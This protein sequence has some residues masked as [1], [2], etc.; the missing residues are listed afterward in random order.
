MTLTPER[1]DLDPSAFEQ[2]ENA[3]DALIGIVEKNGIVTGPVG[4]DEIEGYRYYIDPA[5]SELVNESITSIIGDTTDKKYLGRW[6]A[7]VTAEAAIK[8]I[9]HLISM[10]GIQ[11][12]FDESGKFIG[13]TEPTAEARDSAIKWLKVE[14]ERLRELASAIG[15]YQH[16]VLE[17]LILDSPGLDIPEELRGVEIDGVSVDHDGWSDGL[18]NFFTDFDVTPLMAEAT[19]CNTLHQLAGTL[20]LMA[21]IKSIR[22]VL[23]GKFGVDVEKPVGIGDL[24]TGKHLYEKA[25]REQLNAYMRC[26]EVWLDRLGN[27]C[28]MPEVDFLFV[29]HLRPEFYRGYKFKL[30]PK[31]ETAW[32]RFLNRREVLRGG[33]NDTKFTGTIVYPPL[34]DGS[35]PAPLIEDVP[36]F[37]RCAKSLKAAGFVWTSDL[38]IESEAELLALKGVGPA[39][40]IAIR[41]QLTTHGLQGPTESTDEELL[42]I[43]GVTKKT[44]AEIRG[45]ALEPKAVDQEKAVA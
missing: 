15:T 16:D 28:E 30:V 1:I 44:I 37:S 38:E 7:A 6:I 18:L 43:K 14:S 25:I 21:I 39:A 22:R 29:L 31:D 10:M 36:A 17:G 23:K 11:P 8:N 32:L 4:R 5:D 27:K 19:V 3:L 42:L 41:E 2:A 20:D 12:I 13:M 24:K 40:L 34:P 45:T 9:N 35:Q 26:D 33:T